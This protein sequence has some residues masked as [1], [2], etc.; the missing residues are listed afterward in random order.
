MKLAIPWLQA[1]RIASL[2]IGLARVCSA[3]PQGVPLPKDADAAALKMIDEARVLEPH[4]PRPD[5]VPMAVGPGP[6]TLSR[7][8]QIALANNYSMQREREQ[9]QA[10]ALSAV[11]IRHGYSPQWRAQTTASS[12]ESGIT[13]D[14]TRTT[15]QFVNSFQS[16]GVSQQLPFG[17]TLGLDFGGAY[18]QTSGLSASYSPRAAISLNQPLLRGAGND[19]FQ[20]PLTRAKRGLIYALRNYKAVRE[21]FAISVIESFLTL[22]NLR[23]KSANL[24]EK[25]R[26]YD[27]LAKRAQTYFVL[28]LETEIEALRAGQENLFVQQDLLNIDLD[29][30]NRMGLFEISLA[31][32]TESPVELT[33]FAIPYEKL[34]IDPSQAVQIAMS[35]RPDLQ[36][37]ADAVEDSRRAVTFAKRGLLPSLDLNLNAN[38]QDSNARS[39]TATI[40]DEYFAG[41]TLSLP[42]ERTQERLGLYLA[43]QTLRQNERALIFVRSTI[44]AAIHNSIDRIKSLENQIGIQNSIFQ[45]S[46][47][48]ARVAEILFQ[49]GRVSNREVIEANSIRIAAMNARLDLV[50]AHYIGV[51][52]LKRDLGVL[53][54]DQP[55]FLTASDL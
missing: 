35:R 46:I 41:V 17:G 29:L 42:L 30:K 14:N 2:F 49:D 19:L 33:S 44:T 27:L 25:H 28:G 55:S 50:L 10:N 47:R 9:V 34:R 38:L 12:A 43:L 23:E 6:L 24:E 8:V 11:A 45:S 26:S 37:A 32:P 36:T 39:S 15:N 40:N 16:V 5:A 4:L 53:D 1:L 48:R 13:I 7:A 54:L 52:Q 3:V 21:D 20:E 22:Q 18:A 51:L 31:L